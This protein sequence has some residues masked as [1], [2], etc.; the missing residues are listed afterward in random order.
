MWL[1][2]VVDVGEYTKHNGYMGCKFL[3]CT[4]NMDLTAFQTKPGQTFGDL[5]TARSE[6]V[7]S[8]WD[9][10]RYCGRNPRN[11]TKGAGIWINE[12]GPIFVGFVVCF[13]F[14]EM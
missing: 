7:I 13:F 3:W 6:V 10:P 9:F 14:R 12:R 11:L 8:R 1:F 4:T 2:F 5:V